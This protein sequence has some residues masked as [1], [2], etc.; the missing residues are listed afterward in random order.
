MPSNIAVIQVANSRMLWELAKNYLEIPSANVVLVAVIVQAAKR[1][2]LYLE[3]IS[4]SGFGMRCIGTINSVYKGK[5]FPAQ[6]TTPESY[7]MHKILREM[8][9]A[10]VTLSLPKFNFML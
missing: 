10:G 5:T 9:D 8:V 3:S 1:Q 7:E 2:L 4:K 6:N